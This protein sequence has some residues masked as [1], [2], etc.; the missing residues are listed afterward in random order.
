[1][2]LLLGIPAVGMAALIGIGVVDWVITRRRWA[3]R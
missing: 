1:M 2:K 3:A